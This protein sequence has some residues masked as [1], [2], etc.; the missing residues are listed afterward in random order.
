M[1][2]RPRFAFAFVP[3]FLLAGC[4]A[5][6][7]PSDPGPGA[8]PAADA[9]AGAGDS[10]D[11][12]FPDASPDV[13]PAEA[14]PSCDPPDMLII[15]D[16]SDSMSLG[17]ANQGSRINLAIS[18]IEAI[19]KPPTD[20]SVRFGLEVLPQVGG[21]TCSSQ[22]VVP[23]KLGASAAVGNALTTMSPQLDYG[24]PIGGAL[25]SALSTLAAAKTGDRPQYVVLVT[26]GGECCSC[27]TSDYDIGIAQQL[28]KAGIKTFVVGFGGDDDPVLLNNLACAG[29]TASNFASSCTCTSAGCKASANIQSYTTPLYFKASDGPAL[30]KALA[31]ITNQTCCDCNVPPN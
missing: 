22:L 20:T 4:V 5:S 11:F 15:L 26:D 1:S 3:L 24:T 28:E 17:V 2:P 9:G 27:N 30:K 8:D 14:G 29:H 7:Q 25:Q 10:G 21:A 31:T 6:T 13:H 23:M 18:A 19:T 16:R 12:Q